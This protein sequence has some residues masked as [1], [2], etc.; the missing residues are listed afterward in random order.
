[1]SQE[2]AKRQLDMGCQ[3]L[4]LQPKAQL[5]KLPMARTQYLAPTGWFSLWLQGPAATPSSEALWAGHSHSLG[6]SYV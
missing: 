3:V 1:M 5:Q 4:C 2:V 6:L